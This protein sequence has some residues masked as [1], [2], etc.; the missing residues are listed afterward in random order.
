MDQCEVLE[1]P[2]PVLGYHLGRHR[3]RHERGP[4]ILHSVSSLVSLVQNIC[5]S[6][7]CLLRANDPGQ[8][9]LH[10]HCIS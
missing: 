3:V 2:A 6:P 5:D 1:R 7:L 9:V 8:A 4:G 10:L